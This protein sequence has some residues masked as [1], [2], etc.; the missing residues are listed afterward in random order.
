M[1][2]EDRVDEELVARDGGADPARECGDGEG[3]CAVEQEEHVLGD[4]EQDHL[5]PGL[6]G[7]GGGRGGR[8][9]T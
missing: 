8:G 6:A 2:P 9:E 7:E 1:S 3:E 5:H 4:E